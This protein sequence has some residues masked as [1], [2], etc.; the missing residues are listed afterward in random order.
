[1]FLF[2]CLPDLMGFVTL[3]I[4]K[5]PAYWPTRPSRHRMRSR[6]SLSER[7]PRG[8]QPKLSASSCSPSTDTTACRTL[9]RTSAAG[10]AVANSIF[11]PRRAA[12][13]MSLSIPNR[14]PVAPRCAHSALAQSSARGHRGLHRA[15][16]RPAPQ[17]INLPQKSRP[18]AGGMPRGPPAAAPAAADTARAPAALGA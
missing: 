4:A 12:A 15:S 7:P 5:P 10:S 6:P 8:A 2:I 9:H 16:W 1:M 11:G 13:H 14:S 3:P 17:T 18:P